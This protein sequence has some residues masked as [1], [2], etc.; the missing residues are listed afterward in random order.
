MIDA[1]HENRHEHSGSHSDALTMVRSRLI[2]VIDSMSLS[3]AELTYLIL[4][5]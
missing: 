2:C 5:V 3:R 1:M 4:D